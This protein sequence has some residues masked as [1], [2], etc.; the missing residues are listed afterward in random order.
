MQREKGLKKRIQE[1]WDNSK[2]CNIC[3]IGIPNVIK[4][5]E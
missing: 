4:R 1:L 2:H 5:K 3:V